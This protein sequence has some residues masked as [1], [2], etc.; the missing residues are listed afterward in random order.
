MTVFVEVVPDSP[1]DDQDQ[2]QQPAASGSNFFNTETDMFEP[3]KTLS[4]YNVMSYSTVNGERTEEALSLSPRGDDQWVVHYSIAEVTAPADSIRNEF[5]SMRRKQAEYLSTAE[6]EYP[7]L[8]IVRKISKRGL[9]EETE[10]EE[11]EVVVYQP[12]P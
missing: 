8:K 10:N 4:K 12:R 5:R 6:Q 2:S 7:L 9:T 1:S 3:F 11:G